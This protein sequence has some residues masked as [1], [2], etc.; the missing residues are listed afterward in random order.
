MMCRC[1]VISVYKETN[2]VICRQTKTRGDNR[3]HMEMNESD[4]EIRIG[5]GRRKVRVENS[6]VIM[7]VIDSS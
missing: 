7:L 3:M 2:I 6:N 1:V 5:N 4:E